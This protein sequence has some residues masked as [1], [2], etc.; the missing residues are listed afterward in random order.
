MDGLVDRRLVRKHPEPVPLEVRQCRDRDAPYGELG[1]PCAHRVA[2][3]QMEGSA[4]GG[5]M[6]QPE[7]V[8]ESRHHVETAL[9]GG[10][11]LGEQCQIIGVG[12]DVVLPSASLRRSD[13]R[14]HHHVEQQAAKGAAL[15]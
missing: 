3:G 8:S 14:I 9:Q 4:L 15:P 13:D 5:L 7:P 12:K 1:G 2:P 11:V 6:S 10:G